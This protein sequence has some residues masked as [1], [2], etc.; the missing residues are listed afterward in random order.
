MPSFP[1]AEIEQRVRRLQSAMAEQKVNGAL[2]I[3]TA[4]LYYFAGTVQDAHLLVP[5]EGEPLLLVRK[6][7]ERAEQDSPLNHISPLQTLSDLTAAV[8]STCG[9][10]ESLGLELDI[11]PVNNYRRY[12][13]LF[14]GVEIKDVSPL[15]KAIRMTKS[16]HELEIMKR[17]AVMNDSL[18]GAVPEML[19]E[20]MTEL[21]FAGLAEAYYRKLG[22]QGLVRVRSF[23][24]EVFYGQI[25]AGKNLAVPS[26]SIGPTGGQGTGPAMP[27]SAGHKK[28]GRHEPVQLDYVGIVDG[29]MVDQART[30]FLGEPPDRFLR[31]HETALEIQHALVEKGIPG[32]GA[33]DLYRTAVEMAEAAGLSEGFMGYPSPVPFVG[34]GLGLELDE[35]PVIG[36]KSPHIL[37]EGMTIAVEPKFI[38]PNKGLAGIEN[39]FVVAKEGLK[40]LTQF[41]DAI[42]VI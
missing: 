28:I 37:Q 42:Q 30:Y 19:K 17:A 3:Q 29:Y 40:R 10:V 9:R 38:L 20:G 1:L 33:K 8:A 36:P 41:D 25:M 7:L 21:E 27:H 31:I 26:C 23:N 15:I 6:S 11:L 32:V 18:F 16:P 2:I 22:H 12:V 5:V 24:K 14:P 4:D 35:A 39:T 13:D 34:H